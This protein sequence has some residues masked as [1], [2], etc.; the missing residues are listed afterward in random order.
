MQVF[1]VSV[2]CVHIIS[3][4]AVKRIN[5]ANLIETERKTGLRRNDVPNDHSRP[6]IGSYATWESDSGPRCI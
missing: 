2:E 6:A 4:I 1:L 5:C 3:E